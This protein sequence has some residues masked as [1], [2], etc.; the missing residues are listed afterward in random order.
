VKQ[1]LDG[2]NGS[3]NVNGLAKVAM[4]L[5]RWKWFGKKEIGLKKVKTVTIMLHVTSDGGYVPVCQTMGTLEIASRR[6]PQI[7]ILRWYC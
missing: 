4:N 6:T 2:E 5:R 3:E 1:F 7:S